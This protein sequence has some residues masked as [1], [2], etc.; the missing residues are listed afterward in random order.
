MTSKF[1]AM[2]TSKEVLD[3]LFLNFQ[4]NNYPVPGVRIVGWSAK[5][6][7]RKKGEGSRAS[8]RKNAYEHS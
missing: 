1:V 3:T 6:G 8:G 5:N 7:E 2:A 4:A